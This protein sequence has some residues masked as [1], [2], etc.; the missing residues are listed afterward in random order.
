[1][2]DNAQQ[3]G[4]NLI[5]TDEVAYSGDVAQVQLTR[6]VKVLAFKRSQQR[7]LI[8]LISSLRMQ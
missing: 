6:L 3:N 2:A 4:T 8:T 7:G 1:M 5:A